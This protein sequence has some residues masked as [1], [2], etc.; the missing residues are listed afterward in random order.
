M[1]ILVF[2]SEKYDKMVVWL[3]NM[4]CVIFGYVV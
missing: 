1:D 4:I 3:G 2:R